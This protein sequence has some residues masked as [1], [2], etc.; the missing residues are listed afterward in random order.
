MNTSIVVLS[1]LVL[2]FSVFIYYLHIKLKCRGY[3]FSTF[4]IPF[5]I[6]TI[7]LLST[8][9][10]ASQDQFWFA[11]GF[12]SADKMRFF[13]LKSLHI[14]TIGYLITTITLLLLEF[15]PFNS[16][17]V[18]ILEN[19]ST[20]LNRHFINYLFVI[21]IP[22]WYLIIYFYNGTLPILNNSRTF[23]LGKWYSSI[24]L[25]INLL[26]SDYLFYYGV[27]IIMKPKHIK[28]YIYSLLSFLTL[29]FTGSRSGCLFPVVCLLI[30]AIYYKKKS[31]ISG[32][33]K[34][35]LIGIF[36]L[37]IAL[38]LVL[39]R[40]N[41][42]VSKNNIIKELLYGNTFS[43]IRDG[44]MILHGFE[45]NYAK[46]YILGKTYIAAFLSFIPSYIST[47]RQNWAYGKFVTLGLFGWENHFGLRGGN[48]MEA[49]FNFGY[50]GI[51]LFSIMQGFIMSKL[52]RIFYFVYYKR[53]ERFDSR[54]VFCMTLLTSLLS[55]F[56][57]SA[58]FYNFFL[59]IIVLLIIY[60]TSILSSYC[61]KRMRVNDDIYM[62]SAK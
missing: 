49:Y 54:I 36:F 23:F 60:Y 31:L 39:V 47:F 37:L 9:I 61:I 15:K 8:N 44:A 17:S 7:V 22:I 35:V 10:F 3:L 11:L 62:H 41:G 13:F 46:G 6:Y 20:N 45:D 16:K 34:I 59:H 24:Y 25:A 27:N 38:S 21:I 40:S 12:N 32:Q 26:L 5:L 14:N 56:I 52:E 29:L 42:A 18:S 53:G 43:D 30:F 2:S 33:F 51:I 58:S 28:Y 4:N 55:F 1:E 19:I 50:I 48:A 57:C